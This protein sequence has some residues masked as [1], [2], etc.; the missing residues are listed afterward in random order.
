[1]QQWTSAAE[2]LEALRASATLAGCHVRHAAERDTPHGRR[3][4][5]RVSCADG[6]GAARLLLALSIEDS[7]TAGARML[8]L[9]LRRGAPDDED[10]TRAVFAYVSENVQ[11]VRESGEVFARADYTLSS[12]AG[13]CDDHARVV[14]AILRAGGVPV[15]LNFLYR[16]G[17]RGPRHV[18]AQAHLKG[19]GWTWLE[20]TAAADFGEHPYAA[21]V[22]LGIIDSRQ[23]IGAEEKAMTEKDLVAPPPGF[24][25]RNPPDQHARDLAALK[26]LGFLC[27]ASPSSPADPAFRRAVAEVQRRVPGVTLE[28]VDGLIGPWTRARIAQMLPHDEGIGYLGALSKTESADLSDDFLR[29]VVSMAGSFRARGASVSAEDFLLVW[30]AESGIRNIRNLAGEPYGGLNQMGPQERKNAGFT[31]TFDQWIALPLTEQLPFVARFYEGAA[32]G[33]FDRFTDAASLYLATFAPAFMAHADDPSFPLYRYRPI[34]GMPAIRASEAEWATYNATHSDAYAENRGLDVARKG[35][36]SVGDLRARLERT[37]AKSAR[38][39]SVSARVR[40]LGGGTQPGGAGLV[41]ALLLVAATT[42]GAWWLG[43][44]T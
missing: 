22:R 31:G 37:A 6:W 38:W 21:A 28:A 2:E 35:F 29:S 23:D 25:E 24:L 5:A 11:F 16:R 18:A 19:R 43:G 9:Q 41:V 17:D 10:F 30:L 1:V 8:A 42:V 27:D 26:A 33:H 4:L 39:A 13:D 34:A 44:Q 12:G 36:I 3:A 32:Q 20:T 7:K 14:Y 15:R 40:E